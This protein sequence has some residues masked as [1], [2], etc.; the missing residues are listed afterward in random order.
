MLATLT[1]HEL[2]EYDLPEKA[3]RGIKEMRIISE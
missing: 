2:T 3:S 1:G